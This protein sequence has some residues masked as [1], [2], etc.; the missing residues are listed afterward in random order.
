MV[1]KRTENSLCFG[2]A[3]YKVVSVSVLMV[4][5]VPVLMESVVDSD[6]PSITGGCNFL[7]GSVW[8]PRTVPEYLYFMP[9]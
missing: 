7:G 5:V 9:A 6:V 4:V 8:G 1:L 3:I 2:E